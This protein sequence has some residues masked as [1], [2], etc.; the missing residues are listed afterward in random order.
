MGEIIG[1]IEGENKGEDQ[2]MKKKEWKKRVDELMISFSV[3]HPWA[4]SI[5]VNE[6]AVAL[7]S[8]TK[9]ACI[10]AVQCLYE[11]LQ[12]QKML[13]ALDIIM[14]LNMHAGDL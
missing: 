12:G 10:G 8:S 5:N 11:N 2:W 13:E 3:S 9:E 6:I 1:D 7:T 4:Q 14:I